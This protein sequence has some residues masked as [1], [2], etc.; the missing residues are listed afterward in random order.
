MIQTTLTGSTAMADQIRANEEQQRMV[1]QSRH[2]HNCNEARSAG[3][4][5]IY[6]GSPGYRSELDGD[7]D[8][9]ACEP[10]YGN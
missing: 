8:G 3:V 2:F 7:S 6:R 9:I 4:A 5:P 1:E 10:Y